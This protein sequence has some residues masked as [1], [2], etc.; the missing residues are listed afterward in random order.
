[1]GGWHGRLADLHWAGAGRTGTFSSPQLPCSSCSPSLPPL[2]CTSKE[3]DDPDI[4]ADRPAGVDDA[5]HNAHACKG[6]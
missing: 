6:A 5:L 4:N 3:S 1:M 2:A